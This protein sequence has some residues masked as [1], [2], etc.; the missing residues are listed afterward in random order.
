[1]QVQLQLTLPTVF[2][3][4]PFL[5]NVVVGLQYLRFDGNMAV[6][7]DRME[8]GRKSYLNSAFKEG[9]R[10]LFIL[11]MQW[12]EVSMM[13]YCLIYVVH[14]CKDNYSYHCR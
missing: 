5:Y 3:L 14:K 13:W 1:M 8:K 11:A 7:N 10:L 2:G 12:A 9:F 4:S 6:E